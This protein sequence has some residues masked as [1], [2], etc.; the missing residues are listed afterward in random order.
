M[1]L[2]KVYNV[3]CEYDGIK[4]NSYL[5]LG[6]KNVLIDTVL[7]K[8]S[9]KLTENISKI[10]DIS[11]IDYLILNHTENDRAGAV[12]ALL[13]KNPQIQIIATVAGL[14]NLKQQLNRDF[15]ELLAKSGMTLE[16]DDGKTLKF[17]ITHNIN[18]PDSMMTLLLEEGALFSCDAFSSEKGTQ[19]EY[20]DEKL[21]Y[22]SEY[23]N[24]ACSSLKKEEIKVIFPGSGEKPKLT[25]ID[26]YIDWSSNKTDEC[27]GV[28]IVSQSVSGNSKKLSKRAEYVLSELGAK[29]RYFDVLKSDEKEILESIY[30]S[31]AI[32]FATPT[33]CRNIPKE[34]ASVINSIN[35]YKMSNKKVAA[36]GSYGWS[37]EAANLVYSIMRARHFDTYSSPFRVMFSPTEE[38]IAQFDEF[39]RGFYGSVKST[40]DV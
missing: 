6:K 18:W 14:K 5:I 33:V 12:S 13:D 25:V 24:A 30:N 32:I 11:E 7:P 34:L 15:C 38:D 29:V 1:V 35:H 4:Y 31:C 21:S 22:L 27:I 17:I 19:K 2:D 8:L 39:I 3:G 23:V 36:F 20:Y 40:I 26:D 16:I 9:D 10:I 37:G 28:T